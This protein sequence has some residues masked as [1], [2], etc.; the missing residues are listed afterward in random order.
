[1]FVAP[2]WPAIFH[3]DEERRQDLALAQAT[4]AALETVYRELGYRLVELPRAPVA[5]RVGFVLER[6]GHSPGHA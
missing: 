4:C 5:E 6:L 2:P 3:Q 1:M